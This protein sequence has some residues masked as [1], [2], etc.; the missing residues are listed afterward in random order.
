MRYLPAG[1]ELGDRRPN[2]TTIGTYP[3]PNSMKTVRQAAQREGAIARPI[4]G[5]GLSVSN[6][7]RPRS[8]YVA[9]PSDPDLL[10]EVYDPSPSRARQLASS[11]RVKPVS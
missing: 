8:V 2:F 9:Y 4:E 11:G 6:K 10:L 7:A 3:H 5:G 1:T